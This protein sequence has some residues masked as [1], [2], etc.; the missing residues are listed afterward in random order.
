MANNVN[1]TTGFC[2]GKLRVTC[3]TNG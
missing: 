1:A 3:E 2:M